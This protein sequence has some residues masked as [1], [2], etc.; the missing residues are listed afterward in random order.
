VE[1]SEAQLAR[2]WA[3]M[4][5]LAG[6]P[7]AFLDSVHVLSLAHALRR[8]IVILASPMQ[9]DPFGVPLTPIFFRGIYLPFERQACNCCRQ[10]LILCFQDAHFMP[11]VPLA[12]QKGAG[13]VRVP[14]ADSRGEELP[15][16]FALEDE[17][18]RKWDLVREYMDI[19][20]DEKLPAAKLTCNMALLRRDSS[21]PLVEEM[22]AHFVERG[23]GTFAAER[24]E[25]QRSKLAREPSGPK[26]LATLQHPEANGAKPN[27][28]KRQ[29]QD[30]E[31]QR[32]A[33]RPSAGQPP[34]TR[35]SS[36]GVSSSSAPASSDSAAKLVKARSPKE[37]EEPDAPGTHRWTVLLPR[38]VRPGD[39]SCF[40]MPKGCTDSD[41]I[42]FTVPQN[43][44]PGDSVVLTAKFKVKGRCVKALREVTQLPRAE[45]VQLLI[46][47]HGDPEAAAREYFERQAQAPA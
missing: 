17:L 29:K 36:S 27:G 26:R 8:P 32:P 11:L 6:R 28:V 31:D 2:E 16:R 21:H 42:D 34:V 13:P 30:A 38:G 37:E 40:H 4:V 1:V 7:S 35:R 39:K 23:E 33:G 22:M 20:Q 24:D 44:Y 43:C 10:P 41:T 46:E 15:L 12:A 5:E 14:L 19:E 45:A 47:A 9:R 25:A 3:E 18:G